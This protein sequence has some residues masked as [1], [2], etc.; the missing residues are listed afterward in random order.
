L[1]TRA[2]ENIGARCSVLADNEGH[3]IAQSGNMASL[4]LEQIAILVGGGVTSLLEVGRIMDGADDSVNLCYREGKTENLYVVNIGHQFLLIMICSR[5]PYA[6]RLGTV[7]FFTQQVALELRQKLGEAEYANPSPIVIEKMEQEL[8]LR[9]DHLFESTNKEDSAPLSGDGR[10]GP[11]ELI[12]YQTALTRGL[13]PKRFR[14]NQNTG[15]L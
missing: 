9:L 11:E 6:N 14:E 1:L 15:Y 4:P 7:W 8:E 2:Q 10:Q 12:D 3:I 13:L 5:G